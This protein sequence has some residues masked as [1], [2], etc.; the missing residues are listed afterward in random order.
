MEFY[1]VVFTYGVAQVTAVG[2]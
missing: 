1:A 2:L